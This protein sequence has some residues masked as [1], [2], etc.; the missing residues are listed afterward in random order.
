MT[1]VTTGGWTPYQTFTADLSTTAAK[2]NVTIEST[3]TSGSF[4]GNFAWLRF[5]NDGTNVSVVQSEDWINNSTDTTGK[6]ATEDNGVYTLSYDA[7]TGGDGFSYDL[8]KILTN[9]PES[10]ARADG[11]VTVS[12]DVYIPSDEKGTSNFFVDLSGDKTISG[13]GGGT[14][15]GRLTG[16]S[17]WSNN[18]KFVAGT[19]A[20]NADDGS[21]CALTNAKDDNWITITYTI[22][23]DKKTFN[24]SA[25]SE[26]ATLTTTNFPTV[27]DQ[28]YLNVQP[29]DASAH[30]HK[31][32]IKIRNIKA[33]YSEKE[34]TN[35]TAE[36]AEKA[37][38]FDE[39]TGVA[40]DAYTT[41]IDGS[42]YTLPQ[43]QW[44]ITNNDGKKAKETID[45]VFS[46]ESVVRFGLIIYG[47]ES[48]LDTIRSVSLEAAK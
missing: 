18:F 35:Y 46:G 44:V 20:T 22:D 8:T 39:K 14:A 19:S 42:K 15:Y 33:V 36:T 45:T 48:Q 40:A 16:Y 25:D 43:L 38:R 47:E 7:S 3:I 2:G 26:T 28:L 24:A 4:C 12:Y 37:N 41:S 11:K 23:L 32:A 10:L 31:V 30:D 21:V 1:G 9:K 29:T 6:N 5:Y 34:K 17:P 27:T 13:W